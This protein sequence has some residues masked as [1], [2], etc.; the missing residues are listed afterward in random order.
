[1][2]VEWIIPETVIVGNAIAIPQGVSVD[3]DSNKLDVKIFLTLPDGTP[4]EITEQN[5]IL[6]MEGKYTIYYYA[7]DDSG[8]VAMLNYTF[9]AKKGDK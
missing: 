2:T 3:A 9:C 1:M 7:I 6:S 4:A 5:I 8:N